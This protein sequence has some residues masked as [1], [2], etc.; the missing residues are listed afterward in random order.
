[1]FMQDI[2]ALSKLAQLHTGRWLADYGISSSEHSV[3]VYLFIHKSSNQ[4]RIAQYMLLDKGTIARILTKLED[5]SLLTRRANPA[6]RRENLISLT[7]QGL[8]LVTDLAQAAEK[9]GSSLLA[10]IAPQE[11]AVF[12]A[13]LH[14]LRQNA[15]QLLRQQSKEDHSTV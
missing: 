11:Q 6:N 9:L 1:M 10:D 3:L 14:Q 7:E 12:E 15:S 8:A 13:V 4:E 5:K 2:F